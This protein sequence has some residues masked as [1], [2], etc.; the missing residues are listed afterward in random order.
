[1]YSKV[2]R[3]CKVSLHAYIVPIG[4]FL[5]CVIVRVGYEGVGTSIGVEDEILGS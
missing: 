5:D 4:V 2:Y 1:M 3:G